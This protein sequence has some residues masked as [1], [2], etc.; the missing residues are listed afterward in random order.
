MLRNFLFAEFYRFA[1]SG[2]FVDSA[3]E[4]NRAASFSAG[5]FDFGFLLEDRIGKIFDLD[6]VPITGDCHGIAEPAAGNMFVN[7]AIFAYFFIAGFF[8]DKL[9]ADDL[10]IF[11]DHTAHGSGN[12]HAA[13]EAGRA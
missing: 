4:F 6:A 2:R 8:V 11:H 12:F 5:E 1:G 13:G 3:D 9:P 7:T 10:V